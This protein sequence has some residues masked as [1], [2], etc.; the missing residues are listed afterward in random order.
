MFFVLEGL[1]YATAR[2]VDA[3]DVDNSCIL[4]DTIKIQ[5]PNRVLGCL[6][7][8]TN[9]QSKVRKSP[10]S[11]LKG[12]LGGNRRG[13]CMWDLYVL[14]CPHFMPPSLCWRE[15]LNEVVG[16]QKVILHRDT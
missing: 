12:R 16:G 3:I 13:V 4:C 10:K 11:I 14:L 1:F 5:K 8:S 6:G 9:V 15:R 2:S 7:V